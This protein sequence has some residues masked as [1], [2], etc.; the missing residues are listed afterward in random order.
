MKNTSHKQD[1]LNDSPLEANDSNNKISERGTPLFLKKQI[2]NIEYTCIKTYFYG[3]YQANLFDENI[4]VKEYNVFVS[5]NLPIV[6]AP[7]I[8]HVDECGRAIIENDFVYVRASYKNAVYQITLFALGDNIGGSLPLFNYFIAVYGVRKTANKNEEFLKYISKKA[9]ENSIYKNKTLKIQFDYEQYYQIKEVP[10]HELLRPSA[11]KVF[12]SEPIVN[13]LEKF[14]ACV[15]R[16]QEIKLGLRYLFIG[17]PGTGKTLAMRN[18][19]VKCCNKITVIIPEGQINFSQL[20]EFA[21]HFHPCLVCCDDLDLLFGSRNATYN[22]YAL[23]DFLGCLDGIIKNDVFLLAASNSKE[24]LDEAAARPG[25][26]DSVLPFGRL[27]K[28]NYKQIL[29]SFCQYRD[30]I[31][32]FDEELLDYLRRK[33]ITGAFLTNLLKQLEIKKKLFPETE[34]N[35][36]IMEYIKQNHDGFYNKDINEKESF[37]FER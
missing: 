25:R 33:K 10:K 18:M 36:Y 17:E 30:I 14:S 31:D 37:G 23:H 16:F 35:S 3:L 29:E 7:I 26:F 20:F 34:M 27:N 6:V 32:L 19:I 4:S 12:V 11:D 15:D 24:L 22:P 5:Q 2:L 13:E 1:G 9:I 21:N 8:S 28:N